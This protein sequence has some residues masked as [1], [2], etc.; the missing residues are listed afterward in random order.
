MAE[1]T[2]ELLREGYLPQARQAES[3]TR[4]AIGG[5][6]EGIER[7]AERVLGD[8]TEALRLARDQLD[9]LAGELDDEIQQSEAGASPGQ[10]P[11]ESG[12]SPPNQT[13]AADGGEGA[14]ERE[15]GDGSGSEG[16]P[17]SPIDLEAFVTAGGLEAGGPITGGD[18]GG[19]SDRLREVEELV[20]LLRSA[21]PRVVV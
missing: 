7:A 19:W 12:E 10:P 14:G 2:S 21:S 13:A 8:E 1:L 15:E 16:R 5:L 20:E 9:E 11:D 18:F 17:S 3:R 4:A 6:R